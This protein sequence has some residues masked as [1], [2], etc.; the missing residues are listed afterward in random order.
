MHAQGVMMY[1]C[2]FP[3][4][5]PVV[6]EATMLAEVPVEEYGA[7]LDD[8]AAGTLSEAG[9]IRPPVDPFRVARMLGITVAED[10]GQHGRGRYVRLGGRHGHRSRPTVL[11]RPEDRP[12]RSHWALAH[13]I[14][15]H[16]ACRVFDALRVSPLEA[17]AAAR[18][19]VANHLAGRLLVPTLWYQDDGRACSWDL[20]H[21]KTR[22]STASHEL[23]ARRML[24]LSPP[25]IVTIVDKGEVYFRR[26]NISGRVPPM[27]AM[28]KQCQ[29]HV[30][31]NGGAEVG[32]EPPIRVQ[33]WAI[34]EPGWKREILRTEVEVW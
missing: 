30:H 4:R 27:A 9:I 18:E 23:L 16:L 17:P 24:D 10:A 26:S 5:V 6:N 21:L 15:E 20:H 32:N 2:T 13:E 34:H 28:E 3:C 12:E 8:V 19:T 31:Q 1:P 14:G 33:A 11:L 22:Y 25:V 29:R 7:V